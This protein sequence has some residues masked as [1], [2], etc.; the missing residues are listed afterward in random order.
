MKNVIKFFAS[1]V[2]ICSSTVLL[3]QNKAQKQVEEKVQQLTKAMIDGDSVMLDKLA[4]HNLIYRHSGGH[5]DDKKEFVHKLASGASDFV[6]IDLTEPTVSVLN[7][8]VVVVWHTLTAKTNDGG[9]PADVHLYV[10]LVWE[11]Q[12]GNWKL[13]ARQ[14]AKKV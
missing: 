1:T 10:M 4:S 9:K 5:I 11:K 3:A 2:L 6:S 14:A 13:V 12:H 7:K 8:K